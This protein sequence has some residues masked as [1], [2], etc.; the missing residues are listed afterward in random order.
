MFKLLYTNTSSDNYTG[1]PIAD[2]TY[3]SNLV[4]IHSI[5]LS[6]KST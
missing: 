6:F 5:L 3:F 2:N 4:R 1:A